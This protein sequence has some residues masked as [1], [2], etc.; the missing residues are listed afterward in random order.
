MFAFLHVELVLNLHIYD[1]FFWL[2]LFLT[3]VQFFEPQDIN[4][5][6]RVYMF[7]CIG[8][9]CND[10]CFITDLLDSHTNASVLFA[11]SAVIVCM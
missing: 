4:L 1:V 8:I 3:I 10:Q 6:S 9:H 11:N 7:N 2:F 5:T